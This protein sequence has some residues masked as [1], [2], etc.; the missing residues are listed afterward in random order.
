MNRLLLVL[1]ILCVPL[2]VA[3]GDPYGAAAW[4]QLKF[5]LTDMTCNAQGTCD[6]AAGTTIGG[7]AIGGGG[8]GDTRQ[9]TGGDD[10]QDGGGR[11]GEDDHTSTD[12]GQ[13]AEQSRRGIRLDLPT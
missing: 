7:A 10:Q 13:G 8:G 11:S 2:V 1:L 4:R 12:L 9:Q 3:A 6:L 5:L